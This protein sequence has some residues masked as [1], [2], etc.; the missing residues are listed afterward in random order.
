VRTVLNGVPRLNMCSFLV[1]TTA[2]EHETG[3]GSNRTGYMAF[4]SDYSSCANCSIQSNQIYIEQI[5][6]LIVASAMDSLAPNAN[7]TGFLVNSCDVYNFID[8]L[9]IYIPNILITSEQMHAISP[10]MWRKG[11]RRPF[12]GAQM[13]L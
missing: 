7:T 4:R 5:R 13:H 12:V 6:I 2:R 3:N 8:Y 11:I 10:C 1:Y 9:C